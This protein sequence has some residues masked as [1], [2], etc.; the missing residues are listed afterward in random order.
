LW[1]R[2]GR[3]FEKGYNVVVVSGRKNVATLAPK[4][5]ASLGLSVRELAEKDISYAGSRY[6]LIAFQVTGK[7]GTPTFSELVQPSAPTPTSVLLPRAYGVARKIDTSSQVVPVERTLA[8]PLWIVMRLQVN[9]QRAHVVLATRDGRSTIYD[10]VVD[11]ATTPVRLTIPVQLFDEAG[12]LEFQG[13]V[14]VLSLA[15]FVPGRTTSVKASI[16]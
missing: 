5:F 3:D 13:D 14:R 4:A 2:P 1:S 8:G 6:K 7:K 10:G 11:A 15:V 12:D 16:R 9:H